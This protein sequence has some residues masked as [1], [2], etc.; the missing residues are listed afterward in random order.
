ML[1]K[2]VSVKDSSVFVQLSINIYQTDN[3]ISK[4]VTFDNR[5]IGEVISASSTMIE[6]L[7]IG[8]IVDKRFI[9][10]SLGIPAFNAVC[11]L[12]TVEEIDIIY[13]IDK[14]SNTIKIGKSFVYDNYAIHLNINSFF[15]NH[16]CI[17][18]NSGS[19]KSHFVSSLLQGVFYDAKKLPY[20]TNIFLFDA[21][22]EYQQ[23]FNNISQVNSSLNYKVITTDLREERYQRLFIP[24]WLLTV[25]DICLLLD[26]D[27]VR[28]ISIVEKALK[29]V[30][31]FA[32]KDDSVKAQKNDIIAR[33]LLDI[34]FSSG[35]NNEVRNIY[36]DYSNACDMFNSYEGNLCDLNSK[37][38]V[39]ANEEFYENQTE[40]VNVSDD[41]LVEEVGQNLVT[42]ADN[43]DS[44]H[45]SV[46]SSINSMLG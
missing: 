20:N 28:Q 1:G 14:N 21:Y 38:T 42:T 2:I 36:M 7:L 43:Y 3:L 46:S 39:K 9:A 15:A 29:L 23:A 8:E 44:V 12:T 30:S 27:D 45:E 25:D 16:F 37:R 35:N 4:N 13:G 34:I 26:V 17:F 24:F 33:C 18:G 11:R 6:V 40:E 5:Y 32:K 41:Q 19:G 10:G 22:G 31:F